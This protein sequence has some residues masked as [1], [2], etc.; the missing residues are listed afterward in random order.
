V[1]PTPEFVKLE[2]ADLQPMRVIGKAIRPDMSMGVN[3]I[4]AFWGKC[5]GDEA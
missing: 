1:R 4:P 3:P 5:F 2:T